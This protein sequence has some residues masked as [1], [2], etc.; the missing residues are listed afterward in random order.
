MKKVTFK[1]KTK[2]SISAYI[3]IAPTV[4]SFFIFLYIPFINAI[5]ISFYKYNGLGELTDFVALKNFIKILTDTKFYQSLGN[6]FVLMAAG[7]CAAIPIGFLLAYVLYMDIPGKKLFNTALFIPYLISMVVVGSIWRIIYDPT[8]GPLNQFLEMIGLKHLALPWLSRQSTSLWAIAVTWVWRSVPFNMLIMYANILKM[9][10]DM[11]EAADI[12]GAGSAKKLRYVIIPYLASSFNVLIMLTV[13]NTLRIFDLVWVMT[14]G[15]PGG[16]T[17]VITSY[18][19]RKA[20]NVLDFGGGTAASIILMVIM[21]GIMIVSTI[22]KNL[23][24]E[25]EA[26]E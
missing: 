16:A 1:E 18:I 5:K 23:R 13:T 7:I 12:D 3:I 21:I 14:K 6:T 22:L 24:A 17:E 4:I 11:I 25:G 2:E 9:P 20:F 19:Y 10:V 15:G 8:I 26:Y